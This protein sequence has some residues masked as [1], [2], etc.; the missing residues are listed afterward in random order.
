MILSDKIEAETMPDTAR[1]ALYDALF[2]K[3]LK[4]RQTH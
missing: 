4:A 2:A 1:L 3:Q